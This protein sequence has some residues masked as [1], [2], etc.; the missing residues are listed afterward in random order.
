MFFLVG[1]QKSRSVDR[2]QALS[3]TKYPTLS[4]VLYVEGSPRT[5]FICD[6]QPNNFFVIDRSTLDIVYLYHDFGHCP[7]SPNPELPSTEKS[8]AM[9]NIA[10]RASR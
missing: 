5:I 1:T 9:V 8:T 7:V 6:K 10:G 2:R 3:I 4:T